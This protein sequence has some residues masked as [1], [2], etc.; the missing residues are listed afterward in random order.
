MTQ[1]LQQG[2]KANIGLSDS[3]GAPEPMESIR[4]VTSEWNETK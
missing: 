4:F 3:L 2:Q 1:G